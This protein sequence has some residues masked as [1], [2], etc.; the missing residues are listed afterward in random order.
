VPPGAGAR[1]SWWSRIDDYLSE[2]FATVVPD[3]EEPTY[4]PTIALANLLFSAPNFDAVM[5]P[6]VAT[7]DH[8]ISICMLPDKADQL[9]S[10]LEAWMIAV[11]ENALHPQ[12]GKRLQKVQFLSRSHEIGPDGSITWRQAEEGINPGEIM[13]FVSHP[14]KPLD[15]LPLSVKA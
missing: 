6:S 3:G 13:R 10:P 8:A 5:Y 15:A 11:A 2:I 4:K 12:T 9:F 7:A 1:R 14:I